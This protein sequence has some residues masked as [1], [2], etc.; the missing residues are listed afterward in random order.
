MSVIHEE[1]V[2][3]NNFLGDCE[4]L[5]I[6]HSVSEKWLC[7]S[8]RLA[9]LSLFHTLSSWRSN[10]FKCATCFSFFVTVDVPM[11][12]TTILINLTKLSENAKK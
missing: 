5:W 2:V 9:A 4:D 11:V 12:S 8:A 3:N 6:C 1:M 7:I 10:V